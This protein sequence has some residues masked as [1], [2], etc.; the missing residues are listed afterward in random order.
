MKQLSEVKQC[1]F[2]VTLHDDRR[3][4]EAD[5]N[6]T[7]SVRAVTLMLLFKM[8]LHGSCCVHSVQ[9]QAAGEEGMH[10]Y[11][12]SFTGLHVTALV[13]ETQLYL[14]SVL[15]SLVDVRL[16]NVVLPGFPLTEGRIT[17]Y[18]QQILLDSEEGVYVS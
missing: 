7:R 3:N 14:V 12:L 5:P 15:H 2:T 9:L 11:P 6:T 4:A 10:F 16:K 1:V 13:T 18:V 8:C 17:S